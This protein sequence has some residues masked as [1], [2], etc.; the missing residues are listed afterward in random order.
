MLAASV[1]LLLLTAPEA[2]GLRWRAPEGCPSQADAAAYLETELQCDPSEGTTDV[3]V[4]ATPTGWQAE[5]R[6]DGDDPRTLAAASCED[7]M[8]AAMVVIAVA[9]DA[10]PE[11][12]PEEPQ[13]I[14]PPPE[15][16]PAVTSEPEPDP[17]PEPEPRSSQPFEAPPPAQPTTP[18]VPLSHWVGADAGVAAIHVPA[19]AARLG[20]RYILRGEQWAV[21]VGGH[22]ETPR[23][24]LYPG[25]TV[26]G[27]FWTVAADVM[28]C[29]EPG[30]GSVTG[31]LC[32]GPA[33][34]GVFGTGVGVPTPR[35]PQAPWVGGHALAGLRWAWNPR[36]RLAV[37]ALF[38]V[39][40]NRPAFRIGSRED[41]FESPLLGG[42]GMLGIERRLP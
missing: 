21:R 37:D 38:A 25:T 35:R 33:A 18:R 11:V 22:Y 17:E 16:P 4:E 32:A 31:A 29:Y 20:V 12:E 8:A 2:T 1:T 19:F 7:L 41:L 14:V 36:W 13:P 26:G 28:G 30:R 10:Q 24:L 5:V 23:R 3:R 6:I 27:R 39:G 34:G 40:L 15:P 9:R 42:A